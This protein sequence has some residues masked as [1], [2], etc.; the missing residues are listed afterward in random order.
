[1]L[2]KTNRIYTDVE[3]GLKWTLFQDS[4]THNFKLCS[5]Y[6]EGDKPAYM[7][8]V[9]GFYISAHTPVTIK[10]NNTKVIDLST[11]QFYNLKEG[12]IITHKKFAGFKKFTREKY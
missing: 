7:S 4:D 12:E 10:I 8:E 9:N 1:M 3:T 11:S 2:H 5:E 6:T